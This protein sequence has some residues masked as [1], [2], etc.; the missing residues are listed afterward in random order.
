MVFVTVYLRAASGHKEFRGSDRRRSLKVFGIGLRAPDLTAR[1]PRALSARLCHLASPTMRAASCQVSGG[2]PV[3]RG[4]ARIGPTAPVSPL[5]P[6]WVPN[7]PRGTLRTPVH[8][9]TYGSH[10]GWPE[11]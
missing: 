8:V 10:P 1:Q 5:P 3:G 2:Q 4:S 11:G 7:E 6:V 9:A